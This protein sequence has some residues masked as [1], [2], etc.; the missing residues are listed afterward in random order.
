[1]FVSSTPDRGET[2]RVSALHALAYCPR[3]FYLEEVEELYTQD[4]SVFAGRRLHVEI[5]K[6]EGDEYQSLTLESEGSAID[7]LFLTSES[8]G[9][10]KSLQPVP[11]HGFRTRSL[12]NL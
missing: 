12:P 6:E 3:L 5:E 7:L 9:I 1:M 2:I 10:E 4:A 11:P 8:V